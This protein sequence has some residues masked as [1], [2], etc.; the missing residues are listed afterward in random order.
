MPAWPGTL[1][2]EP[3]LAGYGE[4]P[5]AT[6]LRTAMDAG[7]AK[8]RNRFTAGVR[9]FRFT[10]DLTRDQVAAFDTF[11]NVTLEGGTM[12]FT[13]IH[14]RTLAAVS[15]RFDATKPPEYIPVSQQDWRIPLE[16]EILP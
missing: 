7:P 1:P 8:Q 5:P 16:L 4:R 12:A 6:G 11:F 2:D 14:P 13:W 9:K 15:F 3:L 10:L